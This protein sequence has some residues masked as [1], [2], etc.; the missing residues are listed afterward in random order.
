MAT[1][2]LDVFPAQFNL[3][4]GEAEVVPVV[5]DGPPGEGE[6]RVDDGI[7][8]V[9][10]S[11]SSRIVLSGFGLFLGKQSE[12]LVVRKGKD[13]LYEFPLFRLTEVV[14]AS[15]GVS[16]ST[17]LI[18]EL[19]E[20][21]IR[22][23]LLSGG[24][25]PFAMLTSPMLVA[26]VET[27]RQQMLAYDDSRGVEIGRRI[28]AAKL[29]NQ[30]RLLRYFGKYLR[31]A[32]A[33]RFDRLASQAKEIRRLRSRSA[34]VAGDRI[35]DLRENLLGMEGQAGRLYWEGVRAV[36]GDRASF[37][38]RTNR[39]ATDEVNSLL[40]YGYGILYSQ[41]W[42]AVM[43]AGLEPFAGFLHV[44]RPGKP[45]LVLDL[46]EEFRQPV[47][48]R[49][50]FAHINLGEPVGLKDGLLDEETR[51]RLAEKVLGRLEAEETVDGKRRQIR[52]IIQMQARR[53]AAFLR[54]EGVY[55]PFTFKW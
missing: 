46:I 22:L 12:R 40:N 17:D 23:G 50:V 44:D 29:T 55:K 1:T 33:G 31:E 53:L 25:K 3:F 30:E 42:G 52:S 6:F 9:R 27:R 35:D 28:V 41:V 7:V 32:D 49:V 47:V 11:D 51:R 15:R 19:C 48:D 13:R 8:L 45:S 18:E 36:L 34:A 37:A 26:T 43:N 16:V 5:V 38:G 54:G 20:R 14:V 2:H 39:G 24:G 10:S 4:T 21:G